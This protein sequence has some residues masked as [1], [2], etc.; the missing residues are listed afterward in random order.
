[1]K[2]KGFLFAIFLILSIIS[3][4]V[5][6]PTT[7]DAG[8][9]DF[10]NMG[11][12]G[13]R[14]SIIVDEL[15]D[16]YLWGFNMYGQIGNNSTESIRTPLLQT[17]A[18]NLNPGEV[19][20]KVFGSEAN[21]GVI[22]SENRVFAWGANYCG[23]VGNL[24]DETDELVPVDITNSFVLNPG[25]VITKLELSDEFSGVLTSENR[26]FTWG[27]NTDGR[28]GAGLEWYETSV[29]PIDIT[30]NFGLSPG[31]VIIDIDFSE[32]H[33][34]AYT[35]SGRV[36]VWGRNRD[37]ELGIG[38]IDTD[39]HSL[40]IDITS[41][42]SFVAGEV[43]VS[44]KLG[45][46]H[47]LVLTNLGNVF[48]FGD[49]EY[50][51]L[52]TSDLIDRTT[53]TDITPNF[54]LNPTETISFIET[55]YDHSTAISS[56]GR[57]F[58]W[59]YNI[60]GQ[61]G[62]GEDFVFENSTPI[63]ID[64][65]F[66]L[67]PGESI[68]S[69]DTGYSFTMA[70]SNIGN[71]YVFGANNSGQ[72]GYPEEIQ[73][74]SNVPIL[75]PITFLIPDTSAPNFTAVADQTFEVAAI[76]EYDWISL[77]T[78]VTDD[79]DP[80]PTITVESDNVDFNTVG[81]Y[82]VTV[83]VTDSSGNYL[84]D[85]FNVIIEDTIA[86]TFDPILDVIIEAGS[87]PIDWTLYIQNESDLSGGVLTKSLISSNVD[88]DTVGIYQVE[89]GVLDESDNLAYT[90]FNV[91]VIDTT[92]PWFDF[93][94]D[95]VIPIDSAPLD[96]LTYIINPNDNSDSVLTPILIQDTVDY[97]TEGT[98][99]VEVGVSDDSGLIGSQIFM[100]YV[101]EV[102]NESELANILKLNEYE[103]YYAYDF[104]DIDMGYVN[105][106]G[107]TKDHQ[108]YTT[109][110]GDL[111][112]L[113]DGTGTDKYEFINITEEFNLDDG[114]EIISVYG[115]SHHLMAISSDYR[116]FSWGYNIFG[117]VGNG[118]TLIAYTPQDITDNFNLDE[119]EY[120]TSISIGQYFTS[121]LSSDNRV[122]M[123]GA[124][125][126]GA[127]GD[128]TNI[129]RYLP[130]DIT[131]QF[132]LGEGEYIININAAQHTMTA[133]SNLGRIFA[134]GYSGGG[135]NLIGE[136]SSH[137][138]PN[139]PVDITYTIPLNGTETIN[140]IENG[141]AHFFVFTNENNIYYWGNDT[142]T[143]IP[144][145]LVQTLDTNE[146]ITKLEF[147][148]GFGAILTDSN[149]VLSWGANIYGN[150]GDGTIQSKDD[151]VDITQYFH[152]EEGEVIINLVNDYYSSFAISSK[153][154]V[155]T[156]GYN[157][158][159]Q[160][161]DYTNIDK[162]YPTEIYDMNNYFALGNYTYED[163]IDLSIGEYSATTLTSDGDVFAWGSNMNGLL[164][165]GSTNPELS[166]TLNPFINLF[167]LE[168][169]EKIVKPETGINV[170][171]FLTNKGNLY[172][173]GNNVAGE[174]ALEGILSNYIPIN[175]NDRFNLDLDEE[176]IDVNIG[177]RHGGIIT[178]KGRVFTWGYN[179]YGQIGNNTIDNQFIPV[180]I[181]DNFNLQENEY[182]IKIDFNQN[183]SSAITSLGNVYLWGANNYGQIGDGTNQMRLIPTKIS[184][185]INEIVVDIT[186]GY[187]HV[188]AVTSQNN[189]YSWGSNLSGELGDN[190]F[191]SSNL[192]INITNNF[193]LEYNEKITSI[194]AGNTFS[195][196][197]T[198]LGNIFTF[199]ENNSY[200]L[201]FEDDINRP[202]P[203]N[204]I[205]NFDLLDNEKIIKVE[206]GRY[207]AGVI[208]NMGRIFVWGNNSF[209][210]VS[211]GYSS[212][213]LG[214]IQKTINQGD[215]FNIETV[216]I[217]TGAI[218][219]ADS[220][221]ISLR[222]YPNY[223]IDKYVKGVFVNG[224][225]YDE[226][227]K[228]DGY[229]TVMIP[230]T[231]DL[232]EIAELYLEGIVLNN[233][234]PIMYTEE[235]LAQTRILN[236]LSNS[237]YF[238]YDNY[239][240]EYME[241]Y[242]LIDVS[243]GYYSNI[244][245]TSN[246]EVYTWGENNW[247]NLGTG[248]YND[249][250]TGENITDNFTLDEDEYII[251]VKA[252]TNYTYALTNNGKLFMWGLN[253]TGQIDSNNTNDVLLPYDITN[254]F[255]L[256]VDE[257]I[258]SIYVS[259]NR[260]IL[261][262]NQNRILDI[263]NNQIDISLNMNEE[264]IMLDISSTHYGLITSEN[265]VFTW[266]ENE[267]GQL[268]DGTDTYSA[269]PLDITSQ[270]SL[271]TNET[272]QKIDLG[273]GFSVALTSN[274][275]I[276]TWGRNNANQLANNTGVISYVPYNVTEY[277]ILNENEEIANILIEDNL[278][279][280]LTNENKVYT[281]AGMFGYEINE[282]TQDIP[283]DG[284]EF[285]VSLTASPSI[286]HA[287]G[288]LSSK[289]Y[290]YVWG[291][292]VNMSFI[293]YEGPSTIIT[294]T[295]VGLNK[296]E[297]QPLMY[298]DIIDL[299]VGSNY[300]LAITA[301]NRVISWGYNRYGDLGVP[302]SA[303]DY[304]YTETI[305]KLFDITD[306]FNLSSNEII[307]QVLAANNTS[308]AL[309]SNGRLFVWGSNYRGQLCIGTTDTFNNS[310][311]ID[312]TSKV[313]LN[314]NEYIEKLYGND[315]ILSFITSEHRVFITQRYDYDLGDY[316]Y[317]PV[318]ITEELNLLENEYV[319][320]M[321]YNG[322]FYIFITNLNHIYSG[323]NNDD[324]Q[325]GI[326]DITDYNGSEN[327]TNN[328]NLLPNETFVDIKT[329]DGHS[330]VLTS[331][332]RVFTWG[333]NYYGQLGNGTNENV[334]LP[335]E[336]TNYINLDS[337][338]Y[339]EQIQVMDVGSMLITHNGKIFTF[340]RNIRGQLGDGTTIDRNLP[341]DIS[342][343]FDISSINDIKL[344]GTSY[345][346]ELLL[347]SDNKLY[348]W[349]EN[350][351]NYMFE[352][353]G[354][355]ITNPTIVSKD[356]TH[357]NNL[358]LVQFESGYY[359]YYGYKYLTLNI[360]PEYSLLPYIDS[361]NINGMEYYD[362]ILNN[363]MISVR[364]E[365]EQ[366]INGIVNATVNSITLRDGSIITY[367]QS[368][369]THTYIM[370]YYLSSEDTTV[371]QA[372]D[373]LSYFKQVNIIDIASGYNNNIL[374]TDKYEVYTWGENN[375]GQLGDGT[376]ID[377]NHLINITS[378]F[379][380]YENEYIIDVDA[381]NYYA[382]A[383][384]N[385]NRIF[386]IG[387]NEKYPYEIT[388]DFNL[389]IDEN[390]E[391]MVAGYLDIIILTDNFR[392]ISRNLGEINPILSLDTNEIVID[393]D[394]GK[395]HTGIL[396]SFG[397][398]LMYGSNDN[399]QL[400]DGT[401]VDN[402]LVDIT[403]QFDLATDD[404]I[405]SIKLGYVYS[406]ALSEKGEIFTW[407][408]CNTYVLGFD[409]QSS[410]PNP[411][412]ITDNFNLAQ[413]EIITMIETGHS[414]T[415]ALTNKGNMFTW[416]YNT[417]GDL[418]GGLSDN[419][420]LPVNIT[421][422]FD[423]DEDEV[424]T[425]L[426]FGYY[427]SNVIT[428]K[429]NT[430]GFG[431]NTFGIESSI[432][433]YYPSIPGKV[434]LDYLSIKQ[435]LLDKVTLIESQNGVYITVVDDTQLY[436]WYEPY[437]DEV[438]Q[439][440][441]YEE[442]R[443]LTEYLNLHAN[444]TIIDVQAMWSRSL[445]LTSEGRIF[446]WESGYPYD[447]TPT[448][449]TYQFELDEDELLT[450]IAVGM[451]HGMAI[452]NKGR[453][454]TWGRNHESQLGDSYNDESRELPLD[455]NPYIGLHQDEYVIDIDAGFYYS[456]ILTSEYRV[457]TWGYNPNGQLGDGTTETSSVPI[458]I[459]N[460]IDCQE[461]EY[462][463]KVF[464]GFDHT[465]VITNLNRVLAW[466]RNNAGQLGD[467]TTITSLTPIDIT[468]NFNLS[469][470]ELEYVK[471]IRLGGTHSIA[472]TSWGDMYVWGSNWAYKL[473]D[474][475]Q[476]DH[477]TPYKI[478]N[479]IYLNS[480][481]RIV[482]INA[483]N[484][485]NSL[486]TSDGR[487][488]QFGYFPQSVTTSLKD[489]GE[490]YYFNV[491]DGLETNY[492]KD[493]ISLEIY[494]AYDISKMIKS[495][496]INGIK[497]NSF[498][499]ENGK[500]IVEALNEMNLNDIALY[501]IDSIELVTGE[502]IDVFGETQTGV[503]L[504]NDIIPPII[505]ADHMYVE[506]GIG[507]DFILEL[508]ANA[509][510]DSNMTTITTFESNVN[511]GVIG[512][513]IVK[514]TSYDSSGNETYVYR[515]VHIIN[516]DYITSGYTIDGISFYYFE[517]TNYDEST[518]FML[519]LVRYQN[520]PYTTTNDY[521]KVVLTTLGTN[522]FL[523]SFDIGDISIL[524]HKDYIVTDTTPPE[525]TLVGD[526]VIHIEYGGNY[527][528]FGATCSD[529]FDSSCYVT[530]AGDDVDTMVLGTYIITY[531][532]IDSSSN[533]AIQIIRTVIVEDTTNPV[534]TLNGEDTIYLEYLDDYNELGAICDDNY[535]SNCSVIINGDV[536]T[537]ILGTY[538]ITYSYT[539]S[540]GNTAQTITRTV[541]VQLSE[542]LEISLNEGI[543]TIYQG[544]QHIDGSI[545]YSNINLVDTVD[546]VDNVNSNLVG[547]Y[548]I[549]YT[550]SDISGNIHTLI[551]YV[552][553]VEPIHT[554][555]F[556]FPNSLT[557]LEIGDTYVDSGCTATDNTGNHVCEIISNNV[558][559]NVAGIYEIHYE[560]TYNQTTYSVIKYVFVYEKTI[561][562]T[563]YYKKEEE[564]MI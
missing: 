141:M 235:L 405:K 112:A 53:P 410:E 1:M 49:N 12:V 441:M 520:I 381:Y 206:T 246:Y 296:I 521:S 90:V 354:E 21:S 170:S 220:E 142:D 474:G 218:T 33:S 279:V 508:Q 8:I 192:P 487:L 103:Y 455:I 326:G 507:N 226:I 154:R 485:D 411:T 356:I 291:S 351:D 488:I 266:G 370:E 489:I 327:I 329:G 173:I 527:T 379:D 6:K 127:I 380:L 492:L 341:V 499:C 151:L 278:G 146:K 382:L 93:I 152:L 368:N 414:H 321:Q 32:Y 295:L 5:F 230:N 261:L 253:N 252:G 202:I 322:Y 484:N 227:Y 350:R 493:T 148:T 494:P 137:V 274:H 128:G 531:D 408:Y 205:S 36:F 289:G 515:Y 512:E 31:E 482:Y 18:L 471:D 3:I 197:S 30:A 91:E 413:G 373:Q 26:V 285:I 254:R 249:S 403:Y 282:F 60:S 156:W 324:G 77:V 461:E 150:I 228:R 107:L 416:G 564:M 451:D 162:H 325:L 333:W 423:L 203:N 514:Y 448:D 199:G 346:N 383:R 126:Y 538:Y 456:I 262:T 313:D 463:T 434:Y 219:Y 470:N 109:G 242:Q 480:N 28:L 42:F 158:N 517:P 389:D 131:S 85:T 183:N 433:P 272:I 67:N 539:D 438:L 542:E 269:T 168:E 139:T 340:G 290:L 35:S 557:T 208:T 371:F 476:T 99:I 100:V 516:D 129:N 135:S 400:G 396:T 554:V 188:L 241:D 11:A 334:Y 518:D 497:Y 453:L 533:E 319:V 200:Q 134:W 318:D 417:N 544:T 553:I 365:E 27:C 536:D 529:D 121:A 184:Q 447:D 63:N 555:E 265:R 145:D 190:T 81:N 119:G 186:I 422:S 240:F 243:F 391:K 232:Y 361:I 185:N 404:E 495:I 70:F 316:I 360:Y 167:S 177:A 369:T 372:N 98:Y 149:R 505:T 398:V 123:W 44:I 556:S 332:N 307:T 418:G 401:Y 481:E 198:S 15:G 409:C 302:V 454:F 486:V 264:I 363:G 506:V 51:Q 250:S 513:Y 466:G 114:E 20:V 277:F 117:Q 397:R 457:F 120:I 194:S 160:L 378:R 562:L 54:G 255:T 79:K 366:Y 429:F 305:N 4:S 419:Q 193:E 541:I 490:I 143:V 195:I 84:D 458:D 102:F 72:L 559:T 257:Q 384:T 306:K 71:I 108:I 125:D 270:F 75:A 449:I 213:I 273:D 394:L 189:I 535:D 225:Y 201:G 191:V 180:D 275:K 73:Y 37:G 88:Y 352:Y 483:G 388:N 437:Y 526:E 452:T 87:S 537:S 171:A 300:A 523:Y 560:Y 331:L 450:Q 439:Q 359:T 532:A 303:N 349:G 106:I 210:I 92:E 304:S 83:R 234:Y 406:V 387:D 364:I 118:S 347:T 473:G 540:S 165:F 116:V 80:N 293:N 113:G 46:S 13:N 40:P 547:T 207:T 287:Y 440:T 427:S 215:C 511:W 29:T 133:I 432:Y 286:V 343:K 288:L 459:T 395:E 298:G 311:P 76:T 477:L 308:Y 428:N 66:V 467:G 339:V 74:Q 59:G 105:M 338:D 294:P 550:V 14:H 528:E 251:Q 545:S 430:Y 136:D 130:T 478:S 17:A 355:N 236:S 337:G 41:L 510:D 390:I 435:F 500:I 475:T 187:S 320:N 175:I 317:Y 543:D 469:D 111:G 238:Q 509:I 22:T 204:I 524:V 444:E 392:L 281:W 217:E 534:I 62:N 86:P 48:A 132:N 345:S 50:G 140:N 443:D 362:Y 374:L 159:G 2:S 268:G 144:F 460:N 386:R 357:L 502:I 211:D 97:S 256:N 221:Y 65:Y 415:G 244:G 407:G 561:P 64:Q 104:I 239:G 237:G 248:N 563:L 157:F 558:N 358:Q 393:F 551:R 336:I 548:T 330:L 367:N 56:D 25:E 420:A 424:I 301:D 164:G 501:Q 231:F 375:S 260:F 178:S 377:S 196:V 122:F 271:E 498:I 61:L 181:T 58:T 161:G 479:Y 491:T 57:V 258:H 110:R 442:F 222:I 462:V 166:L 174:L 445:I 216:L 376:D 549:T 496:T 353:L 245:L 9:Y 176:I 82:E 431:R 24:I 214:P 10:E 209:N 34:S 169:N 465:M 68:V 472:L 314:E 503:R 224:Q 95:Q 163:Y 525:I 530:I 310:D 552:T 39:S 464:A 335:T 436:E 446:E 52:G 284:D 280:A 19:V 233:N 299:S 229:F 283:L 425:T 426:S 402:D 309:T 522:R 38:S 16:I 412:N 115:G 179:E 69:V 223:Q 155:F 138:D 312:I 259:E 153:G 172:V 247:G 276:F 96:W 342:E 147:A 519:P 399:G 267:Y 315:D 292:N 263:N 43:P 94:F 212:R 385:L 101:V 7:I 421:N 78:N 45:A 47:S 323:G 89:L 55:A 344:I 23:Q 124:N 297:I 328:F 504:I 348:F 468:P 182:I 546:I